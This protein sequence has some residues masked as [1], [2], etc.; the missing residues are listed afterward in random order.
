PGLTTGGVTTGGVT[1]GLMP[2]RLMTGGF[3]RGF[4]FGRTGVTG[5]RTGVTGGRTWALAEAAP[6]IT[7]AAERRRYRIIS[8]PPCQAGR[9]VPQPGSCSGACIPRL[10]G[11]QTTGVG[12]DQ[13]KPN[14]R[15]TACPSFDC[16][17]RRKASASFRFDEPAT[18]AIG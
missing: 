17:K 15:R 3:T 11:R 6:P 9:L 13:K 16:T 2:G 1:A 10:P 8:V 14:R 7:S 12:G 4:T 5:G 18:T